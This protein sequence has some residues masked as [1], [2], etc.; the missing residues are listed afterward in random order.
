MYVPVSFYT[1][2]WC[3][4]KAHDGVYLALGIEMSYLRGLRN[5]GIEINP[6]H[7]GDWPHRVGQYMINFGALELVSYRHLVLLES[8][9][10]EFIKN[11]DRLLSA[12]I[13]RIQEL[14]GKAVLAKP[15]KRDE[16]VSLWEEVRELA[17]WRNRIA[18]NPVL[19]SWKPGS[20][21]EVDPPDFLG[22]PDMKQLR[23]SHTTDSIS[24]EGIVFLIDACVDLAKRLH[25]A[26]V[27]IQTS[28]I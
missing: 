15:E 4:I 27:W 21:S 16:L 6:P 8:S 7:L 23:A 19:P 22:V 10:T 17:K 5:M 25:E 3:F 24:L 9:E 2:I 28:E 13:S 18:H 26:T 12:R 14:L 11:T 1:P 20:N